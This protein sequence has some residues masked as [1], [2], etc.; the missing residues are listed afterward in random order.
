M[1]LMYNYSHRNLRLILWE[2]TKIELL[3]LTVLGYCSS[4][5][6]FIGYSSQS[7]KNCGDSLGRRCLAEFEVRKCPWTTLRHFV[8]NINNFSCLICNYQLF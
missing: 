7:L 8:P 6:I 2:E 1:R 3:C 4:Q 5:Q